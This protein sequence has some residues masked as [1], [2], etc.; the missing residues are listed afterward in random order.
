VEVR[1]RRNRDR[2]GLV[3]DLILPFVQRSVGG[4]DDGDQE[5]EQQHSRR[6]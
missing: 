4:P 3:S 6:N 2:G 5:R 1:G